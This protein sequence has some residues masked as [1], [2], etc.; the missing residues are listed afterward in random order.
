M[1]SVALAS[2]GGTS[3]P[4]FVLAG[5]ALVYPPP[6]A[7]SFLAGILAPRASWLAGGIAGLAAAIGFSVLILASPTFP[8]GPDAPSRESLIG[9]ALVSSPTFGLAI[10]AFAGFYRRFLQLSNPNR[11]RRQQG[12]P[13]RGRPAPRRR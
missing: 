11:G 3:N 7:T 10:G 2:P 5:Q 6:M 13:Q 4:W 8:T 12:R 1:A 9:Y